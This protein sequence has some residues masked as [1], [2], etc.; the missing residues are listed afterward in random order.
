VLVHS[1][2]SVEVFS[3]SEDEDD[4]EEELSDDLGSWADEDED[5]YEKD[6]D[7]EDEN[8]DE[9]EDED[10]DEEAAQEVADDSMFVLPV[11]QLF[12][13]ESPAPVSGTFAV[14]VGGYHRDGAP[15]PTVH[16]V[17]SR[18]SS[19]AK[20]ERRLSIEA[21]LG[22]P[23]QPKSQ[24][25]SAVP[26]AAP[27][28]AIRRHSMPQAPSTQ[29]AAQLALGAQRRESLADD[30]APVATLSAAHLPNMG[31]PSTMVHGTFTP[32]SHQ[33]LLA[34]ETEARRL[35]G[36]FTPE[37]VAA[38]GE[39]A[40]ETYQAAYETYQ[41]A[42]QAAFIAECVLEHARSDPQMVIWRECE[43]AEREVAMQEVLL[44]ELAAAPMKCTPSAAPKTS[45]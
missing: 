9:D 44:A 38:F 11:R 31:E 29:E 17:S 45:A 23:S 8:E 10:E 15:P 1:N 21:G 25:K 34:D 43:G 27:P 16:S 39:A 3:D 13:S 4:E 35:L 7:E 6:E 40:D 5:I 42:P 32:L 22:L 28:G 19:V 37:P 2:G 20:S 24:P 14:R 41:S 18:L 36:I 12:F 26:A 33:S 30:G